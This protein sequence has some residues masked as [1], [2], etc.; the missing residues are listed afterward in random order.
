MREGVFQSYANTNVD[1]LQLLC[2]SSELE[3]VLGP[4]AGG[5]GRD[6]SP[7]E[8]VEAT[9]YVRLERARSDLA[10]CSGVIP[11]KALIL[12][13]E[14][15]LEQVCGEARLSCD[16]ATAIEVL[17]IVVRQHY[18]GALDMWRKLRG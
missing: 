9:F 15:F 16:R 17:E 2:D 3:S 13:G 6:L 12:F 7:G 10:R 11:G 14:A 18:V 5:S 1:P 4:R 8:L